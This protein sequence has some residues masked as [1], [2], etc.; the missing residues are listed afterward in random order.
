[1][2]KQ[3]SHKSQTVPVADCFRFL[4]AAQGV[5]ELKYYDGKRTGFVHKRAGVKTPVLSTVVLGKLLNHIK[6]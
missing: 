5:C 3:I 4:I 6:S 1:M 2:S